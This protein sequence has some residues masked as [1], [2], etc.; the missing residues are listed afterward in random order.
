[1]L[2]TEAR[3]NSAA[4]REEVRAK[5]EQKIELGLHE[6]VKECRERVKWIM[7][8]DMCA[9]IGVRFDGGAECCFG[10]RP[11][12]NKC[13]AIQAP[14]VYECASWQETYRKVVGSPPHESCLRDV[15]PFSV[16]RRANRRN[17][18]SIARGRSGLGWSKCT[19]E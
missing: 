11:R 7:L 10:N 17:A 6:F 9:L 19:A 4:D 8:Q 18:T 16:P 1:M 3:S 15:Q 14:K 2:P 13:I 5:T 12:L